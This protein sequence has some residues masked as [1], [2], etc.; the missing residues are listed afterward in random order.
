MAARG[1]QGFVAI[2]FCLFQAS[3]LD[4]DGSSST[5]LSALSTV[6]HLARGAGRGILFLFVDKA[7]KDPAIA[8][9]PSSSRGS[10]SFVLMTQVWKD[11]H[12]KL[13]QNET[14]IDIPPSH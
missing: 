10:Y 5:R 12:T 11:G 13:L 1:P 8:A 3:V 9:R 6:V 7:G 4:R 2:G 14:W